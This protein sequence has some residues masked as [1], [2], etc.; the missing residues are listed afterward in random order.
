MDT[1]LLRLS[2]KAESPNRIEIGHNFK[3][4]L[5]GSIISETKSDNEDGN[6]TYTAVF[7]PI[8][9]ETL[10]DSGERLKLKDTRTASQIFRARI[11]GIWLKDDN[12]IEFKTY[13]ENLM[14]NLIAMAP[15]IVSMYGG[16]TV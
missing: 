13:Y 7:K 5:E 12:G 1:Y 9:I 3:V 11:Y 10:S 6:H 14:T 8:R 15:E 16:E 2:G 4:L